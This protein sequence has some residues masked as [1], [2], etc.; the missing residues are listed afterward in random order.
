MLSWRYNLEP[1][2]Q[3]WP[4]APK[5]PAIDPFTALSISASSKTIN[6]DFPPNSKETSAKFSAEFLITCL[7]VAGPPVKLILWTRGWVVSVLPHGSPWPEIIFTT[8]GGNPASSITL[9]NS[10]IAA[11]ACS[12]AFKT[13]VLP[14]AKA[15]PILTATKNN[16][17]F[18][19][20]MAATTPSGSLTLNAYISG[21]SIGSVEPSILS[22][23]PA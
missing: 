2:T 5:I 17:E 9:P 20:T 15:G 4:L 16:C 6:G 14:A 13:T 23:S 10:N 18:H 1:A 3:L 21:L 11:E 8:P 7:A 19:G 12:E 22:A